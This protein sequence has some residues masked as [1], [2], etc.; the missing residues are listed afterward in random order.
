LGER[1]EDGERER[2]RKKEAE[3]RME[4]II[5]LT[6]DPQRVEAGYAV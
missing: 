4:G 2:K 5:D 3:K 6:M 1:S